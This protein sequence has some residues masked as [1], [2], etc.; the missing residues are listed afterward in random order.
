MIYPK[1]GF[2]KC[3]F[4]DKRKAFI[5]KYKNMDKDNF[6]AKDTFPKEMY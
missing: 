3:N 6:F 5:L 4:K 1:L 2:Q